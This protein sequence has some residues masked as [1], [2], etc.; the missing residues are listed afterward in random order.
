MSPKE[1]PPH[2]E[3]RFAFAAADC[4]HQ[5][6]EYMAIEFSGP[7]SRMIRVPRC[8]GCGINLSDVD[9][10]A[11]A[12]NHCEPDEHITQDML[13]QTDGKLYTTCLRCGR[14]FSEALD[15]WVTTE[16]GTRTLSFR[17]KIDSPIA[18]HSVHVSKWD[19]FIHLLFGHG[20]LNVFVTTGEN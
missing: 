12:I 15:F 7:L 2:E 10:I 8:S 19:L 17:R 3:G 16:V 20:P 6:G 9:Q 5:Y 11:S 18:R 4:D 1:L 14:K 13:D